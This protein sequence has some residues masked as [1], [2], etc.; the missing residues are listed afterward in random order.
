MA[1][2]FAFIVYAPLDITAIAGQP[3]AMSTTNYVKNIPKFQG[4]NVVNAKDHVNQFLKVC[5]DMLIE[6]EDMAMKM[7]VSTLE[8][9]ARAWYKGNKHDTSLVFRNFTNINKKENETVLEFNTC[10]SC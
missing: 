6:H 5:D 7:F 4:N 10:F 9:E 2:R 1:T 3:N 8:G